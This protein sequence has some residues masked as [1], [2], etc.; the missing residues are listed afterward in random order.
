M[1]AIC[2]SI[3]FAPSLIRSIGREIESS[4]CSE[5]LDMLRL[6]EHR[7][8][9][10]ELKSRLDFEREDRRLVESQLASK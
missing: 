8:L 9:F 5:S 3:R 1:L 4:V 7:D 2:Y 6:N 10:N